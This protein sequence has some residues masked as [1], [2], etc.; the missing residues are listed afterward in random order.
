MCECW[1]AWIT[2]GHLKIGPSQL[3]SPKLFLY[4]EGSY[5]QI[6]LYS[7]KILYKYFSDGEFVGLRN[8][9]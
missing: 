6:T 9:K 1:E 2:G 8:S 3:L 5:V 4:F 7:C